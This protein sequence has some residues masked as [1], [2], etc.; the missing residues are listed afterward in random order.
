MSHLIRAIGLVAVTTFVPI[1]AAAAEPMQLVVSGQIRTFL[2][3]RPAAHEPLPTVIMLHEAGGSAAGIARDSGLAQLAP[4]RDL[5][6]VFPQGLVGN[7]WN[8]YPLGKEVP[9]YLRRTQPAGVIP[10]DVGFIEALVADLVR[11]GISDPKR[12]YLAGSSNGGFMTLRMV[13]V[14]AGMFAAIGLLI[15]G[16]PERTAAECDAPTPIPVLMIKGTADPTVPYDGGLVDGVLPVWSTQRLLEFFRQRNGCTE[17]AV[18]LSL[19]SQDAHAIEV[20]LSTKCSEAP[21]VLYRIMGGG[22]VLPTNAGRLLLDFF[23]DK[24]RQR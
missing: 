15:S 9:G 10:D 19:P 14:D 20:E 5:V 17:S 2:L 7:R 12:I 4:E 1:C 13:C 18:Q 21:V 11:R 6:A 16:M 3:E 23:R 22:H 24:S 8:F